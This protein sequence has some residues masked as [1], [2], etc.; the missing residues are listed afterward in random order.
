VFY[1]GEI[2][3]RFKLLLAALMFALAP[4]SA[5]AEYS[6]RELSVALFYAAHIGDMRSVRDLVER[7]A[8]VNYLNGDRETPMHA[9]AGHGHLQVMQYLQSQR[10]YLHPRTIQNWTPLHHA[11]RFGHRH[12]ANFLLSNGAEINVRTRT[13]QTVFDMAKGTRDVPMQ[14]L[15]RRYQR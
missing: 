5:N 3:I 4:L 6:Q 7:G 15:L 13:G 8:N 11:V 9:A 2:M 14:N 10:A 12:I 1:Q